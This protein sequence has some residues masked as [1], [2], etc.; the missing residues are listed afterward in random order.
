MSKGSE[1]VKRWRQ[2]TKRRAI[3]AF[4]GKCCICDYDKC[5]EALEFHHLDPA[6]KEFT[7]GQMRG[8]IKGWETIVKELR[9]CV[10][11]C[12]CC[13]REVHSV[14]L[15][16]EVPNNAPRFDETFADYKTLQRKELMDEC[17]VCGNEKPKHQKTCSRSCAGQ[18]NRRVDWDNIDVVNLVNEYKN[19]ELI[20]DLLGVTG[21]AVSR[22]YKQVIRF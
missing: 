8:N 22:R 9:K 13:H 10:M 21:A 12:S 11:L 4:G 16:T 15:D 19:Y 6:K 20:G 5:D 14:Q 17:P 1:A 7:F 18:T 3:E 2:N